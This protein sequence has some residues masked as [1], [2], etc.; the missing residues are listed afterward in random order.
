MKALLNRIPLMLCM[1]FLLTACGG[2]N[3]NNA[4]PADTTLESYLPDWPV[5]GV[6]SKNDANGNIILDW[7][8]PNEIVT[9][10]EPVSFRIYW[11]TEGDYEAYPNGSKIECSPSPLAQSNELRHICAPTPLRIIVGSR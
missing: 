5:S 3:D 6:S 10:H 8:D 2:G 4:E 1:T 11:S 9:N 7:K